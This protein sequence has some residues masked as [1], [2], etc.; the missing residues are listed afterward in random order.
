M[1]SDDHSDCM[2]RRQVREGH[3]CSCVA[4]ERRTSLFEAELSAKVSD[5]TERHRDATGEAYLTAP[6][7]QMLTT[8]PSLPHRY[9]RGLP[10]GGGAAALGAAPGLAHPNKAG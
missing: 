2:L 9:R 4:A 10:L 6:S 5:G 8:A 3:R 7:M 1:T